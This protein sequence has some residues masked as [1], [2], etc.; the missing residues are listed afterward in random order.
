MLPTYSPSTTLVGS[1]FP[2]NA[3]QVGISIIGFDSGV[4][5]FDPSILHFDQAKVF[6]YSNEIAKY[7]LVVL[8]MLYTSK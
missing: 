3:F 2:K 4:N 5:S 6:L 1:N 7:N 8:L